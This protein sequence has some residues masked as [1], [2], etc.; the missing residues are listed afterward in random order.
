MS[1]SNYIENKDGT[2]VVALDYGMSWDYEDAIKEFPV[3]SYVILYGRK[4][5]NL[6]DS[7]EQYNFIRDNGRGIPGN[8]NREICRYHGFRGET[9]GYEKWAYGKRQI[10]DVTAPCS[11][12][13][14]PFNGVI[15]FLLSD[16]LNSEDD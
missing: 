11:E 14:T 6:G 8:M 15:R 3:G 10:L 4:N 16:V 9:E 12:T 13:D 5:V 2:V 1:K 7:V